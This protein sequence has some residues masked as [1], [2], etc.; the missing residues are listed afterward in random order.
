MQTSTPTL[1][2]ALRDFWLTPARNRVLY[3]GR[4]S[5]KSWDAAGF[6]VYLATQCN[7]RV[8]C[9]RQFQNKI[10]ESVY[11]LLK[12]QIGRF[13]LIDQFVITENS[14]KH[15]RT[16]SE[17]MFYGLW[18]HIDEIKSLESIDICWIEEAH[19]LTQEQWDILE[20]TLRKEGSQFWII[21]NPR[22]T[23]DFVYKRFVR[24][25]PPDTIKRHINFNENPF[26]SK[27]ILKVIDAKR[28]EDEDEFRHIYL[29]EP[30]EDDEAVIIKRSWLLAAVDA[31][32]KLGIQPKGVKRIGFDV[33]DS[34]NDKCATVAAH[35]FL[36]T[37]VDEWKAR[38]DEL[39]KSAGRVHALARQLEA[40]I[41]YDSI[42]VGAFAGAQFQSLN[43]EYQVKIDYFRF[44]AGAAVLNPERQVDPNDP[45]SP[46][47]KDFY[48]NLKAQTWWSVSKRFRNTFNAVTKGEIFDEDDLIAISSECENLDGL[49]DELSTPR[50]DFD[51]AGRSK[52]ESKK[53]LDKRDVPSPN[54]ADAFV[55]AFAPRDKAPS[56]GMFLSKR[57][58]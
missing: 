55:M 42:G 35:G 18:R 12:I 17:F 11:T 23:T 26:L 8:L 7:I 52:V 27:T 33:A 58:R 28:N 3:G 19:N 25:T 20:P 46:K 56:A 49:I 43:T 29:G 37:H 44:N 13:G 6:A 31:H 14:I 1:N 24:N 2:P 47:N 22:L 30:L 16:G 41:D 9:A 32:K 34:G 21:F 4:S 15:K 5:S 45:K 57:H 38:E 54:K 40:E 36:A 50:K 51:N 10:A 39:L 53:D 48:A